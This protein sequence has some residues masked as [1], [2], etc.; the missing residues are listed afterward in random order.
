MMQIRNALTQSA[1]QLN[2]LMQADF[3]DQTH[4]ALA[5]QLESLS[6]LH[7]KIDALQTSQ[8]NIANR[9]GKEIRNA[10]KQIEAF[11]SV[12]NY[13]NTGNL[14][15]VSSESHAWPISPDL[16]L[17]LIEM[18]ESEHYDLIIEFGSGYSTLLIA[19]VLQ[20]QLL[21][22]PDKPQP[23]QIAFEHLEHYHEKTRKQLELHQLHDKVNVIHT[24][25]KKWKS[26]DDNVYPYY[27][28]V[29]ALRKVKKTL[30]SSPRKILVLVDG[31]PGSTG[32]HA[33]YPAL[34]IINSIFPQQAI[35]YVLDDYIRED[36]KEIT[37]LWLEYLERHSRKVS[38][39]ERKLEKD[40][41][42]I[43]VDAAA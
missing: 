30:G 43:R 29:S 2:Q 15:S 41:C 33:R 1:E 7:N 9:L 3:P 4:D 19:R 6:K 21:R 5:E 36:E 32:K 37:K 17:F 12:E 35:D 38:V 16:S 26:E 31:P 40:V 20:Q 13:F 8:K 34:P 27:S 11:I 25:L 24:P 14:P 22:S 39:Q 42:V 10:S 18:L 28:C 23:Y